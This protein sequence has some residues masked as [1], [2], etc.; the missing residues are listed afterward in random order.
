MFLLCPSGGSS[1]VLGGLLG[2][3]HLVVIK[4]IAAVI[5][6]AVFHIFGRLAEV[7]LRIEDVAHLAASQAREPVLHALEEEAAIVLF[8]VAQVV[9]ERQVG[10][11][12]DGRAHEAEHLFRHAARTQGQVGE[13]ANSR[14]HF[15]QF[16]LN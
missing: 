10:R 1:S 4:V 16:N 11:V 3:R 13:F 7:G 2:R 8:G 5:V 15:N 14:L 12:H 9:A 6:F